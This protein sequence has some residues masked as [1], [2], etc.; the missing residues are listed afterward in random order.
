MEKKLLDTFLKKAN[1]KHNNIFNYS[2]VIYINSK[3]KII[4]ICPKHGDIEITPYQH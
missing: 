4:V 3:T 1:A 2:K